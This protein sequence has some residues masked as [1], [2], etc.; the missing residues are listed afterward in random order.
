MRGGVRLL[1][2]TIRRIKM[3]TTRQDRR[4]IEKR[5]DRA[6]D[7]MIDIQ[8]RG[9]GNDSVQRILDLLHHCMIVFERGGE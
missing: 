1:T 9:F 4:Y 7:A 6:I 5:I 3:K 2:L 8:D